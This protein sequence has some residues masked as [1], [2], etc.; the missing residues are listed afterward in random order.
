[1]ATGLNRQSVSHSEITRL[2]ALVQSCDSLARLEILMT[3][4]GTPLRVGTLAA[5]VDR[6]VTQVSRELTALRDGG[7]VTSLRR[8]RHV[9]YTLNG[10][11]VEVDPADGTR[12]F[13]LRAPGGARVRFTVPGGGTHHGAVPG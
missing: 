12:S 10:A 5:A 1:M 4:A 9:V 13:T 7:L 11:A 6:D 2:H 8:G 3:L